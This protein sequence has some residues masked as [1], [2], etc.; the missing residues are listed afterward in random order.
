M[1]VH[2]LTDKQESFEVTVLKPKQMTSRVILFSVGNGGLPERHLPLLNAFANNGC[3]VVAPH[4]ERLA[5]P[6]PTEH[7]LELRARRLRSSLDAFAPQDM[8]IHGVG[9][10]IGATMLVTLAGGTAWLG[11]E[12]P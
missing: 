8:P 12:R 3:L 7:E 5:A 10:S 11:P 6:M 9:H 1:A 2:T 4:F